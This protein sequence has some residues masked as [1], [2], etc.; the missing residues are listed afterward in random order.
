MAIF[1]DTVHQAYA[2]YRTYLQ[3]EV[4]EKL[5]YLNGAA[6]AIRVHSWGRVCER[7]SK[8]P[9][10]C[11]RLTLRNFKNVEVTLEH[12]PNIKSR[13]LVYTFCNGDSPGLPF[14]M[15]DFRQIVPRFFRFT[16]MLA[17]PLGM[18]DH[19]FNGSDVETSEV[20]PLKLKT[21]LART[22]IHIHFD[23]CHGVVRHELN[24]TLEQILFSSSSS[25]D[26]RFVNIAT[27]V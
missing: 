8:E 9:M 14:V 27:V 18:F 12:D 2:S 26:L 17:G 5:T 16:P 13:H 10:I 11:S 3:Q 4:Q 21:D 6:E 23:N 19:V 22:P 24:E 7:A 25:S 1:R 20:V 15:H